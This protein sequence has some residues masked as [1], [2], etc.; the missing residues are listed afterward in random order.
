VPSIGAAR[1]EAEPIVVRDPQYGEI[2]FYFYQEDYFPA[3]VRLLAAQQQQ[4][5]TE[6]I[7]QSELLLGGLYLSYGHHLEAADIFQRLLS[8]NV[9][10][11]IRDR[12]WFFLAKIW[13]QRGYLDRSEFALEQLSDGLPDNLRYEANMLHAQIL[14]DN[15]RYGEAV[16]QLARWKGK[17]E[18]AS[19]AKFNLGVARA[20][21]R[22]VESATGIFQE[23][24]NNDPK[25][26][27]ITTHRDKAN[28]AQG[29]YQ[30]QDGKPGLA[31]SPMQ[32]KRQEGPI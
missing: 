24:G 10:P 13:K 4:Q 29:Y 12:T 15:G 30:L 22:K 18:W 14:I 27:E 5:L 8:A 21:K 19:Y 3:I 7:D 25:N 26:E 17:T 16:A 31:K 6:H 2:L 23:H 28:Q 1:G 20:R 9:R 11:E 32:R